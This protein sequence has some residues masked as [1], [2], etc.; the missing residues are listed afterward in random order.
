MPIILDPDT[1]IVFKDGKIMLDMTDD[2]F[3]AAWS[4]IN[5]RIKHE[6]SKDRLAADRIVA[7]R[8]YYLKLQRQK[9]DAAAV[10]KSEG[11]KYF[12]DRLPPKTDD[13]A[14]LESDKI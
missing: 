11:V 6:K 1:S 3:C 8:K 13:L 5:K 9:A 12:L 7:N 4:K 10:V 14:S 2:E